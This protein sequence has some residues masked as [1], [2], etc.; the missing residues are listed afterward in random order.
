[1]KKERALVIEELIEQRQH[2]Y[3][4]DYSEK[5]LQRM[6]KECIGEPVENIDD[7]LEAMRQIDENEFDGMDNDELALEYKI[8]FKEEIEV[9]DE[10]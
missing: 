4:F 8:E 2:K 6:F 1:M 10:I 3:Q 9:V 7:G 5:E